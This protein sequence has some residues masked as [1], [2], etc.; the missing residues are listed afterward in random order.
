MTKEEWGKCFS[1]LCSLYQKEAKKL[2]DVSDVY[3][4]NSSGGISK[5]GGITEFEFELILD[6]LKSNMIKPEYGQIPQYSQ[7]LE[8]YENEIRPKQIYD[9]Q[10][11]ITEVEICN[12]CDDTGYVSVK[13]L[14]TGNDLVF[15]CVCSKGKKII[16]NARRVTKE[17]TVAN[18][19]SY[20]RV[21]HRTGYILTTEVDKEI[22]ILSKEFLAKKQKEAFSPERIAHNKAKIAE[23]IARIG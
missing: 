17:K 20:E 10:Q 11:G 8:L 4:K 2:L 15:G 21:R 18:I 13:E 12:L 19:V 16:E 23:I 3:Y 1:K 9:E 14:E 5:L 22:E 7:L 6:R